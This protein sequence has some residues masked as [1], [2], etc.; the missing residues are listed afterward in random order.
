MIYKE[1]TDNKTEVV[2]VKFEVV[3]ILHEGISM[4]KLTYYIK[5]DACIMHGH[6]C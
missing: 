4:F 5:V 1:G 2:C 3:M 6:L